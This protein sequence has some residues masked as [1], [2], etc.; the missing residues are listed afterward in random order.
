MKNKILLIGCMLLGIL[1]LCS[2]SGETNSLTAETSEQTTAQTTEQQVQETTASAPQEINVIKDGIYYGNGYHFT[3]G[4]KWKIADT[5]NTTSVE[6]ALQVAEPQSVLDAATIFAVQTLPNGEAQSITDLGKPIAEVYQAMEGV[7][8]LEQ[9]ECKVGKYDAYS[10]VIQMAQ[11]EYSVNL[12][13]FIIAEN[14]CVYTI[15]VT[16]EKELYSSAMDKAKE[17]LSTFEIE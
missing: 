13:Q 16:A 4:D 11:E 7:A 8:L 10:V 6:C 1:T 5:G 3:V 12:N 14:G 17:L 2:C 15:M 9:G